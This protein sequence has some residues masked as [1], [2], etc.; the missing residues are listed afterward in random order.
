MQI[1]EI[2]FDGTI[3]KIESFSQAL[4]I[5]KDSFKKGMIERSTIEDCVHVLSIYRAKLDE[6]GITDPDNI[7]VIATSG[8]RDRV[9]HRG[10]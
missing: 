4:S 9:R 7:R 8:Y 6:Y 3:R 10:I 1:A 5:G 2:R